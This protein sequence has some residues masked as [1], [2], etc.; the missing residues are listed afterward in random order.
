MNFKVEKEEIEVAIRRELE[1]GVVVT[2]EYENVSRSDV[3]IE[4]RI[5]RVRSDVRWE[6]VL[7]DRAREVKDIPVDGTYIFLII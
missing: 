7:H 2:Y 4:P 5:R 1:P 3:P 6:D